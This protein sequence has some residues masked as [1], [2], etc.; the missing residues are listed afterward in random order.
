MGGMG[1]GRPRPVTNH[2][3]DG[4][5]VLQRLSMETGGGFFEVSKKEPIDKTFAHIQ[6]ELRNQYSLGFVSD[7]PG[8]PGTFRHVR[9]TV[10]NQKNLAVQARAG[11]YAK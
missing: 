2:S 11:Y 9:V 5:R 1:G 10:P 8:A 6:D 3:D 4:K 7:Q